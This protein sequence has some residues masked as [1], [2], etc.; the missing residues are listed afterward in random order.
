MNT[1]KIRRMVPNTMSE[2]EACDKTLLIT[3]ADARGM[4]NTKIASMTE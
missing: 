2:S 1:N 4:D 3:I